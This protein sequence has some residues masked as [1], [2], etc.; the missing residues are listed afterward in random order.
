MVKRIGAKKFIII[1]LMFLY[2]I[3]SVDA[4]VVTPFHFN[5]KKKIL[6]VYVTNQS[7]KYTKYDIEIFNHDGDLVYTLE[8]ATIPFYWDGRNNNDQNVKSGLYI[9]RL[10]SRNKNSLKIIRRVLINYE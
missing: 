6:K 5:P 4:F 9:I 1:I 10:I 7:L 2:S 8:E 3:K